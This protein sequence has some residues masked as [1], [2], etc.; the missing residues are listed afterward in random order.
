MA[1]NISIHPSS[2]LH[3]QAPGNKIKSSHHYHF[4][5]SIST[6]IAVAL[7]PSSTTSNTETLNTNLSNQKMAVPGSTVRGININDSRYV[8]YHQ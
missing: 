6:P 3:S 8:F 5:T 2:T 7:A 1:T 4:E